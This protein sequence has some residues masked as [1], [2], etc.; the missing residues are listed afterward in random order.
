MKL[1]GL[2]PNFHI[3]VSVNDLYIPRIGPPILKPLHGLENICC[4]A[5]K[6][7]F[8]NAQQ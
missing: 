2:I 4:T 6:I 8:M 5:K 1:R 7:R 3:H